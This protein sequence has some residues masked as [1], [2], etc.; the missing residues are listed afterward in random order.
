[1]DVRDAVEDDA[2]RVAE[3]TGVPT[4]AARELVHDR[5]TRIAEESEEIVGVVSFDARRESVFVTQ[6]GGTVEAV[7]QLFR[8]PASFA[9]REGMG[10]ELLIEESETE[11][12]EAAID[13]GFERAGLGPRFEGARTIEYRF[14]P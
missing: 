7:A 14:E 3:L 1:M 5:T 10:V 4:G 12:E 13:A 2:E 6:F 11:F 8:E 9:R